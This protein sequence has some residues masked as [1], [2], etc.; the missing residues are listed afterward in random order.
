MYK[1][2]ASRPPLYVQASF[3]RP[4]YA[5]LPAPQYARAP[6]VQVARRRNT[7]RRSLRKRNLATLGF[8][9]IE[10]KF[11][12]TSL[13]ATSL[14]AVTDCTGGEYDPT[15]TSMITTPTQGDGEQNRDG[16]QIAC[17][18]I[19]ICGRIQNPS[20][21]DG[22]TPQQTGQEVF[23]ACV[24][25]SQTNGAQMNSEDCFKNTAASALL[26]VS[27]LQRNLLFGKRF[28]ILKQ[29]FFNMNVPTLSATGTAGQYSTNARSQTFRWFIPLNGLKINFNGGTTS[30]V[31]NVIDNSIHV[32]AFTNNTSLSA[33]TISYN[34]RL[35]FVG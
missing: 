24:L 8:L 20:F 6:L 28:R 13:G 34:A 3:K 14:T 1:R 15:A 17:L 19:E 10:R 31:A 18:Y 11:Y 22:I 21:E 7:F 16:K 4:R 35:R 32:I 23:V 27:G 12:D 33:C 26:S 9:G 25:D 29:K 5:N 30:S 2:K